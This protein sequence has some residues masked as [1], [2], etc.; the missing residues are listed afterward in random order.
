[1]IIF[2]MKLS[3]EKNIDFERMRVAIVTRNITDVKNHSNF[4]LFYGIFITF[5]ILFHN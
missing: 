2:Q 3:V 1:M 4:F 5:L